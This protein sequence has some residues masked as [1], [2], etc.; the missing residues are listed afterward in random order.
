MQIPKGKHSQ[1]VPR[2]STNS[3]YSKFH[4][5]AS[6]S[7]GSSSSP[8]SPLGRAIDLPCAAEDICELRFSEAGGLYVVTKP[9]QNDQM[10]ENIM[11]VYAWA[12]RDGGRTALA[13]SHIKHDVCMHYNNSA[14]HADFPQGKDDILQGLYTCFAPYDH[15]MAFII[16]S[17]E[18]RVIVR[19]WEHGRYTQSNARGH[20]LLRVLLDNSDHEALAFGTR[21]AHNELQLFMFRTTDTGT[22][23]KFKSARKLPDMT[24]QS[25]FVA[26]IKTSALGSIAQRH[27]LIAVMEGFAVRILCVDL[28]P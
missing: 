14:I 19:A 10:A 7:S 3:R 24:H 11:H 15:D 6:S 16:V 23:L 9:K 28:K 21:E 18:K 20:R 22:E 4:S 25:K 13:P 27:L 26:A 12:V 8:S 17:Q 2:Y 5:I 1:P